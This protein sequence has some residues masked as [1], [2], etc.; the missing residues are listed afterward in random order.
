[1]A[2]K[3]HDN[4]TNTWKSV[5]TNLASEVRVLGL[6]G[7]YKGEN[8]EECFVEVS[9]EMQK[10]KDDVKYIY[11][12]GT[13]GGGSG[14]GGSSVPVVTIDGDTEIIVNSDEKINI[15]YYFT[16]PN[17]G[18]GVAN[19]SF[20]EDIT[21]VEIPQGRQKW[22]V[23]PFKKG[24][25]IL[26]IVVEDNQGFLSV[27]VNVTVISGALEL[28][29]NFSDSR[30]FTL[31]DNIV[32]PYE[33][34]TEVSEDVFVERTFNGETETV[35]GRIGSNEWIIGKLPFM[36]VNNVSIKAYNS[37]YE[38]NVLKYTLVASDSENLFI[39]TTFDSETVEV[40]KNI[41][42]GYR[43]SMKG[44]YEFDTDLYIDGSLFTTV[45]SKPGVNFWNVGNNLEK[46]PHVLK[47]VARTVDGIYSAECTI[48]F[49]VISVGFE[50]YRHVRDGL[51]AEFDA[52]GKL[53]NSI[54]K[55]T[56]KD[57]SGN[58]VRCNLYNFNYSSNGWIDNKLIFSGKSYAE[59][60]LAPFSE[61]VKNGF[62]FE[63]LFKTEC[64]GNV[65]SKVVNC[66]N[67]ITPFQGFSVNTWKAFLSTKNSEIVTAQFQED[68][69]TKLTY[70]V[71]RAVNRMYIYINGVI[72]SVSYLTPNDLSQEVYQDEFTY[73]GNI[74]LGG[75][76]NERGQ[77]E[78]NS[79]SSIKSVRIYRRAL[80][81]NEILQ[82]Y[83]AD[84]TDEEEQMKL[85]KLNSDDEG[86]PTLSLSGNFA[87][88]DEDSERITQVSYN[89]PRDPSKTIL[90]DGCLLSW[91]GTSSKNY[92]VKNWTIKLREGGN[93]LL[94]Y[95]PKDDWKPE[96]R[97]TIKANYMDSSAA[98]NIGTNKFVYD[99]FKPYPYP[100]QKVDPKTRSN[101]DGFPVKLIINGEEK[102]IYTWNIDRYAPNN[103]GFCT[104]NDD[105]TINRHP[106]AVSYEV[107]VNSS[108]GA[109]AFHDDSWES[110]RSEFKS[111]YNYRGEESEVT[112]IIASNGTNAKVL[113]T[114]KHN[115]LVEL[116][117]WVKNSSD[118]EFY[119]ELEHHFSKRHL[120]DYYLITYVLG[121]VDNFGKNMVLTTFGKDEE[122][123]TIWYPSF[124]DCDSILGLNNTGIIAFDAGLDMDKGDYN[125]SRSALWVKLN[126]MFG[127]EIRQ[128]YKE[129]RL[130]RTEN[131]VEKPPIFSV[132]NLMSYY[133]GQVID[134]IGQR[135]YNEDAVKKYLTQEA[136]QWLFMCN[137]TRKEF[138][139]RWLK[140]RFIYMDSVFEY[141]YDIV[142]S[143]I[144]SYAKGELTLRVKTYS[145]QWI[146]ISFSDRAD[147]KVKKYV[148]KDKFTEFSMY[149]DNG[150]DNNIE[151][152]GCDNIMYLDGVKNLDVRS[153]NI[154]NANKLVE[155]DISRSNR[156][157]EIELGGNTY[158][159]RLLCNDCKN[160]GLNVDNKTLNLSNCKSL[161]EIDCSNTHIANIMLNP[162]G[163]VIENLNCSNTDIT[164]FKMVGQQY[165]R[166]LNLDGCSELDSLVL[167][168]CNGLERISIVDTKLSR[169]SVTGCDNLEYIDISFTKSLRLLDLRGCPNL[170]TL[171]MK[172][173]SSPTI[174]DLDLRS[175]LNLE[176]LDISSTGY[177]TNITFGQ[178]TE[179]GVLKNFNK[180]KNFYCSNS[181]IRSIRYG[182]NAEIPNYL[183]LGG[184][185]L[186]KIDLSSC[187]NV[188]DIRNI[189][190]NATDSSSPFNNC[191]NL[192]SIQG[193]VKLK[194]SITKAFYN[195]NKL[196]TLPTLDLS[197]VTSM[198]ETFSG[199]NQFTFDHV[200][201]IMLDSKISNSFRDSWRCFAWCKKIS[202]T[203]PS[204]LFSRCTG[205]ISVS[206]FFNG[207]S[208]ISGTIHQDLFK[209]M[210]NLENMYYFLS[211]T[212]V[213]GE[214][215]ID[216]FRYNTRLRT[217][218]R[219][220]NST[221]I[222]YV[223]FDNIFKYNTN[224][225]NVYGTFS[226]CSNLQGTIS[227]NIF[228]N[229]R[230]LVTAGELFS[231]CKGIVGTIPRNLFN[232]IP[233]TNGSNKLNSIAAMFRG[234]S[235]SGE[236]PA[237]INESQKGLFDNCKNLT[238][239]HALFNGCTG[240]VGSIPP[241]IFK[242]NNNLTRADGLFDG[243]SGL[244]GAI[245]PNM[246][247][248][249]TRLVNI[250]RVFKNCSNLNSEIPIGFL[251]DC[252]LIN[253][254]TELFWGC[255]NLHGSIPKRISRWEQ[256]PSEDNPEIM[257]D[258]EIVSQ[259]GLFD[260]C[261]EIVNASGVF[262]YCSNLRSEIPETLL[263]N[264]TKLTNAS[265]FFKRCFYLYGP[266]PENLFK[267]CRNL[268]TLDSFFEDCVGLYNYILDEDNPYA[269]PENLFSN[270]FNLVSVR[271]MFYMWGGG[272][273]N[274]PK[275][276]GEIPPSL[277]SNNTKL[278]N[279][280][281]FMTACG[282]IYGTL[283]NDLFKMNT[284]LESAQYA[285]NNTGLTG[286]EDKLFYTCT[287]LKNLSYTFNG[288]TSLRGNAP[289]FWS[290]NYPVKATTFAGCFRGCTS[291]AN[292]NNIP[293]SWK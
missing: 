140:E 52:T 205:L 280:D 207:C 262:G 123:N 16:S 208:E 249:K 177:I 15:F 132:E 226:N 125:T 43:I 64:I 62:T 213:S 268:T 166:E 76:L 228:K 169:I 57:T 242:H 175:S 219:A 157:E 117:R 187:T 53:N 149:V 176:T 204:N 103:Y 257:E 247:K 273:P 237:Y 71:D 153:L 46:G 192:V 129:L 84:I 248:R 45:K 182:I 124:Y 164:S 137:G 239:I 133:G 105:G 8:V 26:T 112:E 23:G 96:E 79:Y 162:I 288:C 275:L 104:Y 244:T 143:V 184:L 255:G 241:D 111:R 278:K 108:T 65:E 89:D 90:K 152:F 20:G 85:R 39:S 250:A 77:T 200:R 106:T 193:T 183:D 261:K 212:K 197:Q 289:E 246:F 230:E 109:G 223:N 156:I 87:G 138:T 51:I 190:I 3:I 31:N 126:R 191:Y 201:K 14:G 142:K 40:G 263:L 37:K 291:L 36:G 265:N 107:A 102:G 229:N 141:N 59:I 32:I 81:S 225:T 293:S 203:I 22:S 251:D 199:C 29:S 131:G 127:E 56:W 290:E 211:G 69:W 88:M 145:P 67:P 83:I 253:D 4:D 134:T 181:D 63:L 174:T 115:E 80:N 41:Q 44:Q 231:Y 42:I 256:R 10:I 24:K 284:S 165:L 178:Y 75:E 188:V 285:F 155:L 269:L 215:P 6:N 2:I 82:N 128:R 5:G 73:D 28:Q 61:G 93:P 217:T 173:V 122:S 189:N 120:I 99:F 259:Y 100:Q 210:V 172:G 35:P 146:L 292:Y 243:C 222:T 121:M 236:I 238:E 232:N 267:N 9:D 139:E 264:A 196:V 279:I 70:V 94:T 270:C 220:F 209:P 179:G 101:V 92:P 13:I 252:K 86:I 68:T 150:T 114:G 147:T 221:K 271:S 74:I 136:K 161:K 25:H 195:C 78:N 158:L 235:I 72:S 214:L 95:A 281:H 30:D 206:E 167:E 119:G 144:R 170:K 160:L 38:S 48:R 33:I 240:L 159:E 287:K 54:D 233:T 218:E 258:Y 47:I 98:N 11:E 277:F 180:L 18:N 224:L 49:E 272:L 135:F 21:R 116:V 216:L 110:I 97:W 266:V 202:G 227:E 234:T 55:N 185:T 194:N 27:P 1:M 91:Q 198:S 186:A 113:A 66:K 12:N 283:S 286:L 163:G 34:I 245:P 19:L 168:N 254:I 154:A 148:G 276:N 274:G 60:Q 260:N 151:I 58:D 7:K 118:E 130:P 17:P 50:P 282:Q 171:I